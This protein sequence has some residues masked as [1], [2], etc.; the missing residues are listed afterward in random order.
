MVDKKVDLQVQLAPGLVLKNPVISASGTF[1]YGREYSPYLDLRQLGALVTKGISL[2]PQVGNPPPRVVETP[3]GML[4][5]IGLENIG[6]AAFVDRE[7]P[8]LRAA[9][10]TVIVN[11]FGT[12]MGDY[13]DLAARLDGE[14]GI[15]ALEINISCPNVSAGGLHFGTDPRM[16]AELVAAVRRRTSLPLITKLTPNV[17]DIVAVARAVTAAGSDCLS[18]I[19]TLTGMAVDLRTRKPALANLTGGLSGPA[20]KPVALRAVFQVAREVE[21]PVIGIGG[22]ASAADALEFLLVGATAVQI[23]TYNFIN[24]AIT[25]AVAAGIENYLRENGFSR[26]SEFIGSLQLP[27]APAADRKD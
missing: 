8:R 5:A 25:V 14:A 3:C 27:E 21:V 13:A 24:P 19:N 18:L 20:I 17:T 6:V 23:G 2:L 10:A 12:T 1:G 4:N 9:G 16:A 22:I 7:L 15:A 26:V 11:I